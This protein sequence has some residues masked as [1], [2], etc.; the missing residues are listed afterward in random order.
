MLEHHLDDPE[1]HLVLAGPESGGVSDDPEGAV[2]YGDAAESWR[3]MSAE[4]RRRAHLV[5]LPM[6][7]IDEN[8]AMVNAIQRRAD[9]VVQKSIAEGFGLTVA[10]AMWKR[11]PVVGSRVGGIQDQIADGETGLLVEDPHDLA[12]FACAVEAILADPDRAR[13]MGEAGRQRV[14]E[15]YLAVYRLREYVDL[16]ASLLDGRSRRV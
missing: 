8:G 11:R 1:V 3:R 9:V 12:A 5:S 14:I 16:V 13:R 4:R 2:V 15:R 10:E 6:Y 7:D